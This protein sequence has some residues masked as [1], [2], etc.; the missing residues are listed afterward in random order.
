MDSATVAAYAA[1]LA[2]VLSAWTAHSVNKRKESADAKQFLRESRQKAY[3]DGLHVLNDVVQAL[4]RLKTALLKPQPDREDVHSTI[5]DIDVKVGF[6]G[7]A[8]TLIYLVGSPEMLPILDDPINKFNEF[9][10]DH[11][12]PF[13]HRH[14]PPT[15][16]G[17]SE[18]PGTGV[19]E[20]M[21]RDSPTLV[22]ELGGLIPTL[23]TFL[24]DF[25][26]QGRRDLDPDQHPRRIRRLWGAS[27]SRLVR[28][29]GRIV[30][31]NP[32]REGH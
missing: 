31:R 17:E 8:M 12:D 11:L 15:G 28:L 9:K 23:E 21:V 22:A 14:F 27:R 1:I 16:P 2:A 32:I 7:Q 3:A 26:Q 18:Y 5:S 19:C 30:S 24:R 4:L 13:Q 29:W 6:A 20:A 10:N 25:Q